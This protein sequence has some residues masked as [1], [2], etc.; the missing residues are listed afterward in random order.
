MMKQHNE[1]VRL[2]SQEVVRGVVKS[3]TGVP[4]PN[5]YF[6]G[7]NENCASSFAGVLKMD[8][9]APLLMFD[10]LFEN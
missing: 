10:T 1:V 3:S 6:V 5:R 8:R 2:I 4:N 7:R 9:S